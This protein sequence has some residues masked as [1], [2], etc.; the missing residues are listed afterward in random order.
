MALVSIGLGYFL[1]FFFWCSFFL[2]LLRDGQ[3]F[4]QIH[5]RIFDFVTERTFRGWLPDGLFSGMPE[6]TGGKH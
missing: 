4:D 5:W 2:V 1:L 3:I 6:V